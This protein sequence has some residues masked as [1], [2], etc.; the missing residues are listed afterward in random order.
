MLYTNYITELNISSYVSNISKFDLISISFAL[1]NNY[2]FLNLCFVFF[3]HLWFAWHQIN[4]ASEGSVSSYCWVLLCLHL[5]LRLQLIPN[6]LRNST[7]QTNNAAA[8]PQWLCEGLDVTVEGLDD[9]PEEYAARLSQWSLLRLLLE[10]FRY[11]TQE[12]N[13]W[14][15]VVTLRG[16]GEV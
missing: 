14:E 11:Y 4:N 15:H 8:A 12:F 10:F 13:V 16:T 3:T 5:L 7:A 1:C 9:M 6:V 2:V